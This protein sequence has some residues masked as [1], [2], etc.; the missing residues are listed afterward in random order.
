[1]MKR[2][3]A[4]AGSAGS[5]RF[6]GGGADRVNVRRRD[7]A[8]LRQLRTLYNIGTIGELTDGQLLER[9]AT[10]RDEAAELAFS[11]LVERHEAMVWRVCL[12]IIRDRHDA[13]DAF[14]A[15][16]LVLIRKA[17]SL[18]VRDSLGPWLHQ[19][20]C[21]TASCLRATVLRRRKHERHRAEIQGD[22]SIEIPTPR[23]PDRDAAVHEEVD[24]L[25]EKYRAPIVLCDLEGRTHQE[26]AR[27]LGWPIGT[28]KT[29][30]LQGRRLL[31]DRLV[32]RGLGPAVAVAVVESSRRTAVA[33]MPK[34][35]SRG[36][37]NAAMQQSARLLTGFGVSAHVLTLT[38]EVLRA[39]LW[40]RLRYVVVV[41]LAIGI[42]AGGAGVYVCGS[43]E[44]TPK[45]GRTGSTGPKTSAGQP[46]TPES[47]AKLRAQQLATRKARASYEIARLTRELAELA[48][49]E[50]EEVGYPRDLAAVGADIKVAESDL[51]RST[52]RSDWASRMFK[53]GY[54][55]EATKKTEDLNREKAV[56]ALEQAQSKKDVLIKYTYDKTIKELRSA[57]EKAR[58]EELDREAAWEREQSKEMELERQFRRR[59]N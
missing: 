57:V 53:K 11:A 3:T 30:Q 42:G 18:W 54:V 43:Q 46:A 49:E 34:E 29:R 24:R 1:M 52:D 44:P 6:V 15:T 22:R 58:V 37:V 20:A 59:T 50:Y 9:F 41:A 48:I 28:V 25:P 17:R 38:E 21:R 2:P 35:L 16:F 32:H 8:L 7:G 10:D 45:V 47:R 36:A 40:I 23:D 14:Q 55:S 13:E 31:R 19:V 5:R 27:S 12:A 39:M 33:A 51:A 56:F 26:A 4:D